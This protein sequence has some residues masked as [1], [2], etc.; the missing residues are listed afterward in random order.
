MIAVTATSG[1]SSSDDLM[2]A[3]TAVAGGK[4]AAMGVVKAAG[5]KGGVAKAGKKGAVFGAGGA[6]KGVK[7]GTIEQGYSSFLTTVVLFRFCCWGRCR[8]C[9]L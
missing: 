8:C 4:A 2:V 3:E 5:K 1:A 9:W 6:K 7:K